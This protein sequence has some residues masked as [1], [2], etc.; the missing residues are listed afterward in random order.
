MGAPR[1]G[2]ACRWR[3]IISDRV[4][5][6]VVWVPSVAILRVLHRDRLA[7]GALDHAVQAITIRTFVMRRMEHVVMRAAVTTRAWRPHCLHFGHRA[8]VAPDCYPGR[9]PGSFFDLRNSV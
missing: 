5:T 3:G 6:F 9:Y 4:R 1:R 2:A 7:A 8:P